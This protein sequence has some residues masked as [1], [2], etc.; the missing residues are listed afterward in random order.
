MYVFLLAFS[1]A[2]LVVC[3]SARMMLAGIWGIILCG[4]LAAL[5]SGSGF[6]A[7]AVSLGVVILRWYR[8]D[9][10]TVTAAAYGTAL[11]ACIGVGGF[12]A[13]RALSVTHV[14]GSMQIIQAVIVCIA[15]IPTAAL[16]R[17]VAKT[18]TAHAIEIAAIAI[19]MWG[20]I[21]VLAMIVARPE[22]RIWW[23]I[24]RYMEILGVAAFANIG[25]LMRLRPHVVLGFAARCALPAALCAIVIFAPYATSWFA[26]RAEQLNA[27]SERIH[28]YL[29]DHDSHAITDAP[30]D[31]LAYPSRDFLL[32][33]LDTP[34][35]QT[36][37]G[38]KFGTR[39]EPS[40]LTRG[41]RAATAFLKATAWLWWIAIALVAA[42]L[43]SDFFRSTWRDA[44]REHERA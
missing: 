34:A 6:V 39:A 29:H 22:F 31:E 5:S 42:W 25:C 28:R 23:P 14:I 44:S 9:L 41:L 10:R 2:L 30:V 20:F 13:T 43:L 15:W 12:F 24:S 32:T 26:L 33:Q 16:A 36:V 19:S 21:E 37:L 27:Q 7:A 18:R 17:D 4:S 1:S 38:D 35:V 11:T 8:G 3:A 40:G